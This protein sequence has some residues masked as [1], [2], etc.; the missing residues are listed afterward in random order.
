MA[1][2]IAILAEDDQQVWITNPKAGCTMEM[3]AKDHMVLPVA[4]Q[5]VERYGD[6]LLVIAYMNTGGRLKALAG[7]TGGAVCTSSNAHLIVDWGRKTAW[8]LGM[9]LS[10]LVQLPD[11]QVWRQGLKLDDK[12]I[13]GGLEALDKAEMILWGSF[14]GV[15]TIFSKKHVE[16]WKSRGWRVIVH[17]ESPL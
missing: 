17:P 8:K 16:W 10:K 2:A 5:L 13:P 1:E 14:C 11:P 15:H 7:R 12:R 6:D 4:D 3:L 9:D